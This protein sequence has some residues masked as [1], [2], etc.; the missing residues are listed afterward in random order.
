MARKVLVI[1]CVLTVAA[2][3]CSAPGPISTATPV[4]TQNLASRVAQTQN[5]ASLPSVTPAQTQNLASLPSVTPSLTSTPLPTATYTLTPSIT[6]TLPPAE[7]VSRGPYL[8]DEAPGSIWVVWD[9]AKPSTGYV[10]YGP[11][12]AMGQVASGGPDVLVGIEGGIGAHHQ[13]QLTGLADYTQYDYRVGGEQDVYSFRSAAAPGQQD[14]T[15]AVL[16][17]T[18]ANPDVHQA[19]INAIAAARPDFVLHT[20]DLV[21]DGNNAGL[22]TA[23]LKIE[24]PLMRIAPLYPALGNHEN[25]TPLFPDIFR[26]PGGGG[27]G[28]Y[29][30][31][32]GDARIIVLKAD[33]YDASI[34]APGAP[35]RTWLEQ[36][37]AL[38]AGRWIFVSFH[39]AVHT[40]F[41]EDPSEVNLRN[42]LAP[43]FE[44]YHVTIVFNG[45]IHSYERVIADGITYVVTAGGGAPL[46]SFNVK[47]PGQQ[48][49][50][51][52]YNYTLFTVSGDTV[53]G[54][55]I[56]VDGKEID[57]F[58]IKAVKP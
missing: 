13:V 31:D 36:E 29:A 45:H 39:V 5:L 52:V 40:S 17:D 16:G 11:T 15:F 54:K 18:R 21:D 38:A 33:D 57:S 37:L 3:G 19:I 1:L 58:V 35:Q 8:Q 22:W 48:A 46:Y 28:Y 51:L 23:F 47:E 55:A 53:S 30:F 6:P 9:T 41:A 12:S 20:G 7:P 49:A 34:F 32:Y 42:A 56:S 2:A 26:L 25:D 50:A 27:G 44:K 4:E 10:E 43:L 14:F 24:N